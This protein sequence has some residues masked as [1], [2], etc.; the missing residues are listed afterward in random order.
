MWLVR[1]LRTARRKGL[2]D[3]RPMAMHDLFCLA[4]HG[5]HR[6]EAEGWARRA[7]RAYGPQHPRLVALAH[8][9][10]RFWLNDGRHHDALR[11]FRAVLPH[12]ERIPERRL[13]MSNMASAAAGLGDRLA[14]ANMWQETWRLID[15]H[16]DTEAVPN[17]LVTL[18]EGAAM[19]GDPDRGQLAASHALKVAI[20]RK[21]NE[22]RLDAERVL[23]SL[24]T[25]RMGVITSPGPRAAAPVQADDAEPDFV[26]DLV[27]ALNGEMIAHLVD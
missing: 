6:D 17:A 26:S 20:Q 1:A 3:V 19:L 7:F 21:E 2:W 14:F 25:V 13:V 15:E 9:T 27:D 11:V 16:E 10:A 8:D 22:H 18:A 12:I 5:H 23:E 24:R 4:V